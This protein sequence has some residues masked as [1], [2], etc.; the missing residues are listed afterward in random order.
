MK[1]TATALFVASAAALAM[2]TQNGGDQFPDSIS[3]GWGREGS[4]QNNNIGWSSNSNPSW[5]SSYP[6]S[7]FPSQNFNPYSNPSSYQPR[8]YVAPAP[9]PAPYSP[10]YSSPIPDGL[11]DVNTPYIPQSAGDVPQQV[12]I[13]KTGYS[14]NGCP[15]GS[16]STLISPDKTVV[17]FGFDTFQAVIGP[18]SK[19]ADK[20]KNCQLHLGLRYPAGYQLSIMTATYH[21]YVRLDPGVSANFI[22]S[23]YFSQAAEKTVSVPYFF[24]GIH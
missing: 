7:S 21:G 15:A 18:G 12:T 13:E 10:S 6:S 14:G 23:Y 9:I 16:V 4:S 20:Q 2:P 24:A 19:P 22:S 1:I 5:G 3:L 11:S 8:P 17:T